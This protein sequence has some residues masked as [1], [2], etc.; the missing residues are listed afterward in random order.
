M[1]GRVLCLGMVS[2]LLFACGSQDVVE[3]P[4]E[5]SRELFQESP[6]STIAGN[7]LL[8][9]VLVY[10]NENLVFS[11][12]NAPPF[13]PFAE[14]DTIRI[15][16]LFED[17]EEVESVRYFIESRN[18]MSNRVVRKEISA[19]VPARLVHSFS[20]YRFVLVYTSDS[21]VFEAATSWIVS[22]HTTLSD[23]SSPIGVGEGLGGEQ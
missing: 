6:L 7:P 14:S 21:R 17:I 9:D 18:S 23:E 2:Q 1:I 22:P 8:I 19:A 15:E 5:F 10:Q 12:D 11:F 13:S 3:P 20:E 16:A 4:R